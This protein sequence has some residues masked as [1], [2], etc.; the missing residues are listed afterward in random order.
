MTKFDV[1]AI[2]KDYY[3]VVQAEHLLAINSVVV[4]PVLPRDALPEL[5]KLTVDVT[6]MGEAFRIRAHMPV[7]V[8]AARLQGAKIICQL[9]PEDGQRVMDGLYTILWGL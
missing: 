9:S 8:D 7:T 3:L 6:I 5:S 1:I 4:V 2:G